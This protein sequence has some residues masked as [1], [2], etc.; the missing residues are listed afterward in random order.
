M[1]SSGGL[2]SLAGRILLSVIFL[3]S[4]YSKLTGWSASAG[5]MASKGMPMVPVLLAG[6]IFVEIV[7]GLCLLVGFQARIVAWV[8]FLYLIPATLIFHNFWV[9]QG[10]ERHG[11]LAH[12]MKNLAIMGGLLMAAANGAGP[13]SVDSSRSSAS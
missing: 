6:A 8:L 9:L 3:W 2:T 7:G 11:M 12:F 1:T 5:F 10:M 4:G 13:L